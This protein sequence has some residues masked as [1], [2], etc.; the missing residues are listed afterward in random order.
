MQICRLREAV[1]LFFITPSR[2]RG[3]VTELRRFGHVLLHGRLRSAGA[4]GV[5]LGKAL[6]LGNLPS[7]WDGFRRPAALG[8]RALLLMK[9]LQSS[10]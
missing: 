5:R 9:R 1:G 10:T 8:F 3:R 7:F 6:R 4:L 2:T